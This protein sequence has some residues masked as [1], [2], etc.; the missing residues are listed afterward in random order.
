MVGPNK[1]VLHRILTFAI[2]L[3]PLELDIHSKSLH[4]Y[5]YYENLAVHKLIMYVASHIFIL[6]L[7]EPEYIAM[8]GNFANICMLITNI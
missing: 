6:E 1:K 2:E 4:N 5:L 7:T 8:Y 3:A